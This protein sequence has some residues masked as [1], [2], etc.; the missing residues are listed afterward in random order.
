[1]EDRASTR[2]KSKLCKQYQQYLRGKRKGRKSMP[3]C[4]AGDAC[5]KVHIAGRDA[6]R[7]MGKFRNVWRRR[8]AP[9]TS[10]TA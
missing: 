8:L 10:S 2:F 7:I 5:P 6:K 1:M 3:K 9:Y 4:E